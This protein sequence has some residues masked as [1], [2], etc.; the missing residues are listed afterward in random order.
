MSAT[1]CIRTS[2]RPVSAA[3]ISRILKVRIL[4]AEWTKLR[5][6][7][8][9]WRTAAL[10]LALGIGFSVAVALSQ[11][12]QWHTM[13]TQQRQVFDPTSA[14]MSGVMIAAVVLGTL[15]VR[16]I[17]AEYSTGMIRSTFSAMPAR[18]LVLAAKAAATAAFAFP[19][20]LLGNLAGFELGQR[21]FASRHVAVTIG[22]PGVL[23]AMFFG[24]VAVSL[25]AMIGVGIGGLIRHTAGAATTLA[26]LII[27]G[28][29]VGQFLPAGWRQYLPGIATQAAVTVHRSAGL[30][31]PGAALVVLAV[32]AAIVLGAASLRVAHR[33]A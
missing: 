27:G 19:V 28:L 10:T 11:I 26:L 8:S 24:A 3:S 31:R 32:Y 16:T 6:L 17:T 15:A 13:T 14:S 20:A 2:A 4:K 23:P 18:P 22:H 21:I 7:P 12:S 1:T 33:D 30:L 9:T 5:T 29:T 25:V